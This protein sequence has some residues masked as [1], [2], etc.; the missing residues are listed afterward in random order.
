MVPEPTGCV[1]RKV[2]ALDA[3]VHLWDPSVRGPLG[4]GL[5][6]IWGAWV[7]GVGQAWLREGAPKRLTGA[8]HCPSHGTGPDTEQPSGPWP[9][10]PTSPWAD[11]WTGR[12]SAWGKLWRR[13]TLSR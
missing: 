13:G 5:A 2:G 12:Q 10:E 8:P 3:S 4:A 9:S 7:M 6:M 11:E 1:G